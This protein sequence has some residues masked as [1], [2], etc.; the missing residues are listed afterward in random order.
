MRADDQSLEIIQRRI[1]L[2][3]SETQPLFDF[4]NDKNMLM[5]INGENDMDT[6][7]ADFRKIIDKRSQKLNPNNN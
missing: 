5:Y 2:F 1:S 3:K 6:V 7:F 4:Y